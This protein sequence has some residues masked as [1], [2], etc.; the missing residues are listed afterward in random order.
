MRELVRSSVNTGIAIAAAGALAITPAALPAEL[1]SPPRVVAGVR[2]A[3]AATTTPATPP[4]GALIEQFLVNQIQ[5][6]SL[7]CP[8]IIQGAIQAPINFA[9]IPFTFVTELQSGQPLLQA[10]ALTDAT[11][12]GAANAALTGIINNDL[13]LVLPRAQ[14]ALEVAVVGLIDIGTTAFTQL[15][16]LVQAINTARTGFFQALQ[17]PPGTMPPPAVHNALEAAAVRVIE[18][19]SALTFQAPERLL[20]G[21]T[22][23]ADALFTT[24]GNTGNVGA[25]LGA[26]GASVATTVSQSV[27]FI[28]HALTEPI[29]I[30]PA[31]AT[32]TAATTTSMTTARAQTPTTKPLAVASQVVRP[33]VKAGGNAVSAQP[34]SATSP[35]KPLGFVRKADENTTR[36]ITT[37][38]DNNHRSPERNS[39]SE[40]KTATPHRAG[41]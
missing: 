20:L 9:I 2:L 23:V 24:L 26:A 10:I 11:V 36:G 19:V 31:A 39:V 41:G 13:G 17:Q 16:N 34:P 27:A 7:I 33:S 38:G 8:F 14:N 29:P 37:P 30:S 40:S 5:D 12:S 22:Q 15:G 35:T 28:R 18:V 3:A 21:V 32:T 6:C 4:P 1:H 25:T